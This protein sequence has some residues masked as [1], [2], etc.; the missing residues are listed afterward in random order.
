MMLCGPV[1]SA[2]TIGIFI[3]E[4]VRTVYDYGM[5][6]KNRVV[7]WLMNRLYKKRVI[8]PTQASTTI[9]LYKYPNSSKFRCVDCELN[10]H[11]TI[12]CPIDCTDQMFTSTD[13]GTEPVIFTIPPQ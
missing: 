6:R 12:A 1:A 5:K 13:N 7:G 4:I 8:P 3:V 10:L 11:S 2:L 9:K